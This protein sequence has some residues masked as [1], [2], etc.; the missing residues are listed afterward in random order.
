MKTLDNVFFVS[1]LGMYNRYITKLIIVI[2][3]Y[4]YIQN[5]IFHPNWRI[6]NIFN[7][8][9]ALLPFLSSEL[10]KGKSYNKI[11][12]FKRILYVYKLKS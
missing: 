11:E 10:V 3:F 9:K 7:V 6:M 2:V 5:G 12:I 1:N 8:Q 4:N